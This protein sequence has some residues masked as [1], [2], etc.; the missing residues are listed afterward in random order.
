[1]R[2]GDPNC[3]PSTLRDKGVAGHREDVDVPEILFA[4]SVGVVTAIPAEPHEAGDI[5]K[6]GLPFA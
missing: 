3:T 1:L 4:G 2:S 6:T 5:G